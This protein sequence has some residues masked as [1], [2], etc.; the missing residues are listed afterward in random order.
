MWCHISQSRERLIDQPQQV[1]F[2]DLLFQLAVVEQRFAWSDG[3]HDQQASKN[4]DQAVHRRIAPLYR[5]S[6]ADQSDFFN[7][8]SENY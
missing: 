2:G 8:R 4:E 7:I 3:Q 5:A 6:P 1:A